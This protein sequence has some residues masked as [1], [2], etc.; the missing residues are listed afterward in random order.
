MYVKLI[1]AEKDPPIDFESVLSQRYTPSHI[2]F[3]IKERSMISVETVETETER[4]N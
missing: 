3:T 4:N 2:S 1:T